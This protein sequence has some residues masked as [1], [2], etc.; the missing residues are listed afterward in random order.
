MLIV[1][2]C[3]CHCIE[4][5]KFLLRFPFFSVTENVECTVAFRLVAASLG[6]TGSAATREK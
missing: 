2:T 1:N 4:W 6:Y 3:N 5:N